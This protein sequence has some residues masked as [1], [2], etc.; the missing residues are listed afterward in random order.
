M[1]H[2]EVGEGAEGDI[3]AEDEEDTTTTTTMIEEGV[4]EAGGIMRAEGAE[5][6]VG[7][8]I[9]TDHQ[10]VATRVEA[11]RAVATTRAATSR[12]DT[13]AVVTEGA[14]GNSRMVD[15]AGDSEARGHGIIQVQ[16]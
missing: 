9:M 2:I 1:A 16:H 6:G 11:T 5:V 12:E 14:E 15:R 3:L 13:R 8:T 10:G 7:T 4:E